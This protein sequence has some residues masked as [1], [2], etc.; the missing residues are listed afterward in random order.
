MKYKFHLLFILLFV[1]YFFPYF[2]T[3]NIFIDP[4]DNLDGVAVYNKIIAQSY[5]DGFD[6]FKIFLGG[7]LNWYNF[8]RVFNP[9]IF[10][11]YLFDFKTAY[12]V[13]KLIFKLIGFFSF[14]SLS[15]KLNFNKINQLISSIIYITLVN[16]HYTSSV[17]ILALPYI[18]KLAISEKNIKLKN[19]LIL[20]F[21]GLNSSLVFDLFSLILIFFILPIKNINKYFKMQIILLLAMVLVNWQLIFSITSEQVMHRFEFRNSNTI[22]ETLTATIKD[23]FL[24]NYNNS[25]YFLDLIY[26][27]FFLICLILSLKSKKKIIFKLLYI[28]IFTHVLI[29]IVRLISFKDHNFYILN[30]FNLINFE[31]ISRIQP[32]IITI[33]FAYL[34]EIKKKFFQ[35][36]LIIS[37]LFLIIISQTKLTFIHLTKVFIYKNFEYQSIEYLKILIIKKDYKE[38]YLNILKSI[39]EGNKKK[40][41]VYVSSN[42]FDNYY[43]FQDYKII[44]KIVGEK[45]VISIG[46]DPLIA[47]ANDIPVVDGYH[48]LYPLSYK[49]KFRKIIK[50]ELQYNQGLKNYFDNWGNRV[51]VFYNNQE[52]LNI[53]FEEAR[54][55]GADF[56][57]SKFIIKSK[58]LKKICEKC[59]NNSKLNLYKIL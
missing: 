8:D 53:N 39:Q 24:L 44:K 32:L 2:L 55:I 15:K 33:L 51:Y 37:S 17:I 30:I 6:K 16:Y 14:L 59:N 11:Y 20:L 52:K 31:R 12:F 56:V 35:S 26:S 19:Y 27:I 54:N 50:Q 5:K 25:F 49:K 47:V 41:S 34:F 7:E 45:R 57:I 1:E 29:F 38:L 4:H 23:F 18:L 36:S 40:N 10:V 3:G 43:N 9:L 22:F 21:I 13:E 58:F 42:T 46:L 48:N 28:L